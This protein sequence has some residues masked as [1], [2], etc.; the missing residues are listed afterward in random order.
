MII[1]WDNHS[2]STVGPIWSFTTRG[3]E[4]PLGPSSPDPFNGETN[5][6]IDTTLSWSCTDPDGDPLVYDVYLDANNP[7]PVTLVSEGKSE[8]TFTPSEPLEYRTNYYWQIVAHDLY[9]GSTNGPIWSFTTEIPEPPVVE[10][11]KPKEKSFYI[12]NTRLFPLPLITIVYGSIDIEVN[13]TSAS[14]IKYVHLY[15]NGK[16]E[17]NISNSP[18]IFKWSPILCLIYKIKV[19]AFDNS[20]QSSEDTITVLKWRVHPVLLLAGSLIVLKQMKSPFKRTL[21]RGTVFNLR[22]VGNTYHGRAIRLRFTEFS[23]LT[24]VSGV[25]KLQRISFKHSLLLRKYDIGPLG[26][27]TYIVGIIP[28]G[29]K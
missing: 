17:G 19:K 3:N 4:P 29:I 15:I 16:L 22:R 5:V 26:L 2:A 28:G 8:T 18:Y 6:S 7:T 14:G 27:T 21:V 9:G 12:A 1:A 10:I 11:I 23:G 13:A 20:G 25:I 24:R